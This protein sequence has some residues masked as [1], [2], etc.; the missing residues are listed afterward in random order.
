MDFTYLEFRSETFDDIYATL[1]EQMLQN[2]SS[3][4]AI[5]ITGGKK[6]MVASAAI[7]GKDYNFK[8]LYVDFDQYD[9]DLR[10]PIPGYER[11]NVVYDP[12]K[13]FPVIHHP[14]VRI[15]VLEV[16]E[17]EKNKY[18]YGKRYK[19]IDDI[20]LWGV[21]SF[22]TASRWLKCDGRYIAIWDDEK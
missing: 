10:K 6:S 20:S 21:Y 13:Q 15:P 5:D 2:P 1:L 22:N 3:S 14:S 12:I 4:Y 17:D 7:F 8:V 19:V 18:T 16:T 11:L 9:S